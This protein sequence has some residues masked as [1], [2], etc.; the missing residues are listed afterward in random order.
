MILN[1][2]VPRLLPT[3]TTVFP[4]IN[5]GY[6]IAAGDLS[7]KYTESTVEII[8]GFG[9]LLTFRGV[10][11]NFSSWI[12][13]HSRPL[14]LDF[15]E[16]TIKDIFQKQK[17]AVIIFNKENSAEL[18]STLSEASSTSEADVL[19]VELTVPKALMSA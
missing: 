9:G 1:S 15:D 14:V 17:S 5:L 18:K 2:S 6:Y 10:G 19:F 8:R 11:D 16:R 7:N 3:T 13:K 12:A 4:P